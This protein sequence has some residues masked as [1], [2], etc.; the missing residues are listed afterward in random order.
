MYNVTI[1][2]SDLRTLIH[3]EIGSLGPDA[4]QRVLEYVR[5]LKKLGNGMSAEILRRHVGC[6]DATDGAVM[7]DAVESGCEQVTTDEW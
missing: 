2:N 7:R 3:T 1:M 6:I 5:T 4:Q